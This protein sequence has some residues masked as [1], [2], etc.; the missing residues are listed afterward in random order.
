MDLVH[1]LQAWSLQKVLRKTGNGYSLD[2][3]IPDV[4]QRAKGLKILLAKMRFSIGFTIDS[5]ISPSEIPN[6]TPR[7][8]KEQSSRKKESQ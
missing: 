6:N 2:A 7:T 4:S 1:V 3:D 5:N 8:I